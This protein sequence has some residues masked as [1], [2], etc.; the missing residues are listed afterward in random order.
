MTSV[1]LDDRSV[2]NVHM[3]DIENLT[4]IPYDKEA[5]E[6][7]MKRIIGAVMEKVSKARKGYDSRRPLILSIYVNEYISIHFGK[8]E[9]DAFVRRYEGV[10]DSVYP[11]SEVVFWNLGNGGV[12]RVRPEQGASGLA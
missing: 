6:Q 9:L 8:E 11:F 5:M 3:K 7:Y 10:F 2:P 12:C 1:Y 4:D